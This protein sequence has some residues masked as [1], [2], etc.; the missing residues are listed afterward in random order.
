M[1]ASRK[2]LI[3]KLLKGL[4]TGD[5]EAATVV[6]EERY[7]QH[8]P[9]T[10]EGGEGLAALFARLSKTNPKVNLVRV[11]S[12]GEF[13]F[14]HTEYDFA[15]RRIGFEVFRFEGDFAVEHWDNI[16]PRRG[17]N[18]SGRSMVDGPTQ[19]TDLQLTDSNRELVREFTTQVM[20]QREL[21]KL[22]SF[23]GSPF[24]QHDPRLADGI[25]V[26]RAALAIQH[27][28]AATTAT[29]KSEE[30]SATAAMRYDHLHRI[31]AEGCFVLAV[32]EGSLDGVHSSFYDLYRVENRK[33]VE[34]WNTMEAVP[35][36]SEWKNNN[37]KF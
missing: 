3:Y 2:D 31:L 34:H 29:T 23:C 15:T 21:E 7:V 28:E 9:Q 32:C 24:I 25:D 6:N 20:I 12:D 1:S 16:Q 10:H 30:P 17:P 26:W 37:G 14:G 11:F 4:E 33:I 27:D 8:N 19:A 36:K 22:E 13:V 35:P 5:P 18:T